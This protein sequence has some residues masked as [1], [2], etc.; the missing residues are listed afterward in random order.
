MLII[1]RK[2]NDSV[3]IEQQGEG[4]VIEIKLVEIGSQVRLGITAPKE[5][6][7]W[8]KELYQT[9]QENKNAIDVKKDSIKGFAGKLKE[10]NKLLK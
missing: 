6:K 5:C 1:T 3:I 8:R 9:V 4:E 7:I 2:L 10:H